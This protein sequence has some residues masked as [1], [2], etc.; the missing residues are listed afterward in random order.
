METM[1]IFQRCRNAAAHLHRRGFQP[2]VKYALERMSE[3]YHEWRLGIDTRGKRRP[4]ELGPHSVSY[5][6]SDYRS[7]YLAFRHLCI[8]PQADVFLDYGSGMGRVL[9]VA[10]TYPFR[11]VIGIELCPELSVVAQANLL[12][13]RKKLRCRDVEVITGDAA[14]FQVPDGVSH[15]FFYHPFS[16]PV[17]VSALESIRQSLARQPRK[18]CVVF[19]NPLFLEPLLSQ[20]SWLVPKVEFRAC[21]GNHK[22]MLLEATA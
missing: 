9:V 4:Q 22:V 1:A 21:D 2:T 14:H 7:I 3:S 5:Y 13:A 6:P 15:V 19:K 17:L 11:K 10:G 18:V 8:R 12:R 16:G 20:H